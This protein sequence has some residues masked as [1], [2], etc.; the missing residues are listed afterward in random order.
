M[1]KEAIKS[2]Q[3]ELGKNDALLV[4]SIPNRFYLTGLKQATALFS[5]RT[6][7]LFF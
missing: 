3:K 2:I 1:T 7:P 5:S 4:A 6:T